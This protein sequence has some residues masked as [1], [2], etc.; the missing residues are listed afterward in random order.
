MANAWKVAEDTM[1]KYFASKGE[2]WPAIEANEILERIRVG[3]DHRW[4]HQH[5]ITQ[6]ESALARA[7]FPVDD[8]VEN[9]LK[10]VVTYQSLAYLD[11]SEGC[12]VYGCAY[13]QTREIVICERTLK[14]EP[15]CRTTAAHE[16]G[17]VLLHRHARQRCLLY[18]P[19]R[20]ASTPEEREANTFMQAIILPD[21]ILDLGIRY[22]CH[23]WGI[24]TRLV[25]DAANGLRGRWIWRHRLFAPLIDMLC[26]SR[27]MTSIKM[28]EWGY[29]SDE[30]AKHH[31]TYVLQTRWHT[32]LPQQSLVRPLRKVMAGLRQQVYATGIGASEPVVP[33]VD[34]QPMAR[35]HVVTRVPQ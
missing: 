5:L 32:P 10:I 24:D 33:N 35:S 23:V 16:L 13:P 20:P 34:D 25:F 15:L 18:T 22:F 14:Y 27:E 12:R 6:A 1:T 4:V 11:K 31:K 21:S 7:R 26:V 17:H 9:H 28:K 2:V 3:P 19:E 8:L 29:F 30:T